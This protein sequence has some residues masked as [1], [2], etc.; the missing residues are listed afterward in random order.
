MYTVLL[1]LLCAHCV[2]LL[3][4]FQKALSSIAVKKVYLFF[5][6]LVLAVFLF[7]FNIFVLAGFA[8]TTCLVSYRY[9][10]PVLMLAALSLSAIVFSIQQ[11]RKL[12]NHIKNE[13]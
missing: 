4:L 13:K 2:F 5:Q 9:F 1:I 10:Y 7:F 6:H 12:Y 11:C 3:V 8:Y